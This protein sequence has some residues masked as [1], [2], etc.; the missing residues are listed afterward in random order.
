[1]VSRTG[2][3]ETGNTEI[4]VDARIDVWQALVTKRHP[5]TEEAK[6]NLKEKYRGAIHRDIPGLGP[7]LSVETIDRFLD[8]WFPYGKRIEDLEEIAGVRSDREGENAVLRIDSGF[9]GAVYKFHVTNG[10]IDS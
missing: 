9:S 6:R 10:V 8:E 7:T 1:M 3:A 5:G 2:L 4:N